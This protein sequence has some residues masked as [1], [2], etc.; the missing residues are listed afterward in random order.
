M[1]FKNALIENSDKP[2]D[3]RVENGIFTEIGQLNPRQDEEVTDLHRKLVLPPF[4]ESHVHLDTCL[5]A[6]DPVWN[7]SGTLFEGIECWSKRKEKL[8][9]E[10]ITER[11]KRVVRMYA[12]NGIQFIR[13]HIDVTDPSLMAMRTLIKLRE[14]LK[15]IME[16][17][18]VAFPQEGIL[19]FPKGKELLAEAIDLGADAVGAIPHFEFTR[20]YGV[21][22]LTILR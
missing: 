10:D 6:G 9:E 22:S 15:D 3:I 5:T 18:I 2:C 8:N 11:V 13:T 14:A 17:Q 19:S 7:M 20:E 21:E 1:L 12:V 4:I 16:I